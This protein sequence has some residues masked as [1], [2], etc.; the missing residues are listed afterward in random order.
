MAKQLSMYL[1]PNVGLRSQAQTSAK[2]KQ[3]G[4][5][6]PRARGVLDSSLPDASPPSLERQV[7]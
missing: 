1:I 5:V 4:I 7:G 2:I 3:S 6:F